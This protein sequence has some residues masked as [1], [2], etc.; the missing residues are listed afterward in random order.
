MCTEDITSL[1]FVKVFG[2]WLSFL[3]QFHSTLWTKIIPTNYKKSLKGPL[4]N[5]QVAR[6]HL[7]HYQSQEILGVKTWIIL[8]LTP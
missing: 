1:S 3:L 7:S 6:Q 8:P 5:V 2:N 4:K